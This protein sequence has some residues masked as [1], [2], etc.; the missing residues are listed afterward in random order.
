MRLDAYPGL[1]LAATLEE[2]SPL[3][4]NGQFSETVHSFTTRFSV[5][6]SDPRLL[7]DLSAALDVDLGSENNALVI[8]SQSVFTDAGHSYVWA[9][10]SRNF[11]KRGVKTGP[12]NDLETVVVSGLSEGDL[13]RRAALDPSTGVASR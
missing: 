11:E 6:G 5:R 10:S 12:R 7:P 4:H 1:A 8:P 13:V 9:K 2:V 3:G